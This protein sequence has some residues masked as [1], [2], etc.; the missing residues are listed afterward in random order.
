MTDSW[1]VDTSV[2]VPALLVDHEDHPVC[3]RFVRS[4]RPALGGHALVETYS[5]LTRLPPGLR[6]TGAQAAEV[7]ARNFPD[8]PQPSRS[9]VR[10]FL[11][12]VASLGI[13]GG[14]VYDA[15]VALPAVDGGGTLATRDHRALQTYQ[16]LG[17][18]THL[19]A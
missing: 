3:S 12:A 16:L 2:A 17:V 8:Q 18:D 14:A 4:E 19:V 5:I 9:A 10:S 13:T 11:R 1:I 7:I 15:L 6:V